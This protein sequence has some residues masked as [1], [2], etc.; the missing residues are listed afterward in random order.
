MDQA[1]EQ[2]LGTDPQRPRQK[3]QINTVAQGLGISMRWMAGC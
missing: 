2:L 1:Q 3:T